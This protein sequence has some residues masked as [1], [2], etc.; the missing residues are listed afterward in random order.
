MYLNVFLLFGFVW[1]FGFQN[2]PFD[3]KKYT[4]IFQVDQD[5]T[6]SDGSRLLPKDEVMS[7][8]MKLTFLNR[9]VEH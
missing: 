6:W 2:S 3:K 7:F 9:I 1:A 5:F 8:S 4:L